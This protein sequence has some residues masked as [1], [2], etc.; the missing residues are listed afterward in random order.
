MT[1][2]IAKASKLRPQPKSILRPGDV[3]LCRGDGAFDVTRRVIASKTGS[4]YTHAAIYLGEGMVLEAVRPRVQKVPLDELLE[5]YAHVAVF[6]QPDAWMPDRIQ[7][8]AFFASKSVIAKARYNLGGALK[9]F[10]AKADHQN[11][12]YER[13]DAY[14]KDPKSVSWSEK[15]EY[16]CSELVVDCYI[17]AGFIDPSAIAVYQSHTYSP[18][19][20]AEDPTFGTFAG[21]ISGRPG[22]TIPSSDEFYGRTTFDEIFGRPPSDA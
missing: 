1:L 10:D 13:L 14:F 11:T 17:V 19:D 4:Q 3:L 18:G 16:F 9:I 8:L 12:V 22:Y 20:L 21:Y 2:G 5:R 6:R 15:E 7:A